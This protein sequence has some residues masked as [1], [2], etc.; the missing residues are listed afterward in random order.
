MLSQNKDVVRRQLIDLL[1]LF[2]KLAP[3]FNA[4]GEQPDPKWWIERIMETS[5]IRNIEK[6][7]VKLSLPQPVIPPGASVPSEDSGETISG[8]MPPEAVED[9]LA[10][11]V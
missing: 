3:F 7:F 2:Q 9:S 1:G 11:R 8:D 4:I 10:Q 6:G 5:N